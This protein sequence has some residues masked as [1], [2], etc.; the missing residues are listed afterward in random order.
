MNNAR[1]AVCGHVNRVGAVACEM[2]DTSFAAGPAPG[3]GE[4]GG[5]GADAGGFDGFGEERRAGAL[6]TDVPSPQFKGVSDVVAPTLEV[7]RKHFVPVGLLV[8]ATT[9]PLVFVQYAF[10]DALGGSYEVAEDAGESET[11]GIGARAGGFG[12]AWAGGGMLYWLLSVLGAAALSGALACAVVEIQRT[13][14]ARAG[15]CLRWGLAKMP[16]VFVVTA[17]ISLATYA[18]PAVVLAV[19]AAA[20]GPQPAL[21]VLLLMV[22]PWVALTLTLSLAVPAAAVENQ[23]VVGSLARSAELTKGFKGLLFLTYFMWWVAVAVLKLVLSWSFSH[24]GAGDGSAPGLFTALVI[25]TLVD[26]MLNASMSVLTVY[27]FLGVLNERR[28][29][30]AA[31]A[32]AA[33]PGAR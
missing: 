2:C 22:L 29:N 30:F 23:G 33:G 20:L 14:A 10:A 32:S 8:L 12:L 19:L 31:S 26:G 25:R 21:I 18:L 3:A 11:G 24:G 13:G 4:R 28:Q 6:P 17:A 7:Y 1:C 9:L 5:H 15:D 27:I 16:K